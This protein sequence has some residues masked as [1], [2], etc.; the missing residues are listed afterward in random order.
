MEVEDTLRELLGA[1]IEEEEEEVSF[2]TSTTRNLAEKQTAVNSN[3]GS[4]G[5]IFP[6][7]RAV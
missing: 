6:P 5:S 7:G 4:V 2:R 1:E 3:E